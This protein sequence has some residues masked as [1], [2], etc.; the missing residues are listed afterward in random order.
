M[1]TEPSTQH[2]LTVTRDVH[3]RS[4]AAATQALLLQMAARP[5]QV[6]KSMAQ[7]AGE[8]VAA[9]YGQ[10]HVSFEQSPPDIKIPRKRA[11]KALKGAGK[12]KKPGP[13]AADGE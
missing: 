3:G 2:N 12:R 11:G 7:S 9:E 1:I 6:M 10:G 4:M 5:L 8:A 13:E